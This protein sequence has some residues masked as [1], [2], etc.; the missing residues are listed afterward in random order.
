MGY[1]ANSIHTYSSG[2]LLGQLLASI[3]RIHMPSGK[4]ALI[5]S[6]AR[7]IDR[8]QISKN[9]GLNLYLLTVGL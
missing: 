1:I 3:P 7:S 9:K 6:E 5:E 4:V 8:H 2:S